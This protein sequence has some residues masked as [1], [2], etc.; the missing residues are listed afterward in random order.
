MD[1]AIEM[2]SARG[3]CPGEEGHMEEICGFEEY[4][5]APFCFGPSLR[6]CP[7][8]SEVPETA[9][10][11]ENLVG[12]ATEQTY[13]CED[14]GSCDDSCTAPARADCTLENT[15]ATTQEVPLDVLPATG[16]TDAGIMV[17][18][19]VLM[20]AIGVFLLKNARR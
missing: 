6:A 17:L 3:Y 7:D 18:F 14:D 15:V 1:C 13:S 12:P 9:A 10:C 19:G 5:D 4:A 11:P 20:V 2:R 16:I 8:G